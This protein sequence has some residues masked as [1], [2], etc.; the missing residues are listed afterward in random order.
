VDIRS[1]ATAALIIGGWLP[2]AAEWVAIRRHIVLAGIL[3]IA[4]F[5][6]AGIGVI[7]MILDLK[8]LG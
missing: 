1:I 7:L 2:L 8:L 3:R 4:A 5:P 6:L